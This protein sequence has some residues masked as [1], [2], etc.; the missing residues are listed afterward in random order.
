MDFVLFLVCHVGFVLVLCGPPSRVA[1]YVNHTQLLPTSFA[2]N[3]CKWSEWLCNVVSVVC[4]C[5]DRSSVQWCMTSVT[6]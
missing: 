5:V 3:S 1:C 6:V 2:S 4:L